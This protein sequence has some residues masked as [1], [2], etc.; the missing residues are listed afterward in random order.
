MT[1]Q[2]YSIPA[3]VRDSLLYIE[4]RD[5]LSERSRYLNPT[6]EWD[7]LAISLKDLFL[8][9][10]GSKRNIPG[11]STLA[12]Q[13]EK[14]RHSPRGVT[15]T[16]GDKYRQMYSA[17]LRAY[18]DGPDTSL[19][20]QEL[21]TR[22]MNS[23]PLAA[24][25]GYGEVLGLS[26]GLWAWYGTDFEK[27]NALLSADP[28]S[29][30]ENEKADRAKIYRQILSLFLAQR[31]PSYYLASDSG[32]E[33]LDQLTD[34]YLRRMIEDK[35]IPAALGESALKAGT[36]PN[37][38][39]PV[40]PAVQFVEKK[41]QYKIRSNLLGILNVDNLYDLDRLDLTVS[42]SINISEQ[43]KA[44]DFLRRMQDP[45]YLQKTGFRAESLLERGDPSQVMYSLIL[46]E[47]TP[48]GNHIRI[49]TDNFNGPFNI[50]E[51]SRLELGSTAKLRTLVFYLETIEKLHQELSSLPPEALRALP[52]SPKDAIGQWARQYLLDHP[53]ANLKEVLE[54]SLER[55][56]S[57][58]PGERF[59]TGGGV[60]TFAN[61]DP[62]WNGKIISVSEGF[63]N[64]VNLVWIRVMRDIVKHLI[65]R[66]PDSYGRVLEDDRHPARQEYLSRFAQYEGG[67]YV[68]RFYR[69]YAELSAESIL[70]KMVSERR[71]N[72][73]KVAWAFRAV[74]PAASPEEMRNFLENHTFGSRLT[75]G[76]P[77]DLYRKTDPEGQTLSDLGYLASVH[78]L[79]LWVVRYLLEHPG[80]KRSEVLDASQPSRQEAYR[81]LIKSS[82]RKA[83]DMRIRSILEMEA[84]SEV[85]QSWK[86]LGYP[87]D[88]I[89]PSLGT[90]IGSSG[91]RPAALANLVGI[92]LNDGVLLP[93]IQVERLQFAKGTP[94]E[95]TLQRKH[96][97]GSRVL[98]KEV[99][100]A[101]RETL[102]KVVEKGTAQ[103]IRGTLFDIHKNL[104]PIGGKTGTGNNRFRIFA[105][106]GREVSSYPLNRT[107]TFVFFLGNRYFGV[108]TAYI[109]GPEAGEYAFT[110]SLPV[111]ILRRLLPEL[112]L[113][114]NPYRDA[115]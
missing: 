111:E 69:K 77:E 19:K 95:V 109:S 96:Q 17:S 65:Y 67:V 6:I 89:V 51:G 108:I 13:I 39:P 5:L 45:D 38:K 32:K 9:M 73:V 30:D 43:R 81:W 76:S 21:V 92:L 68:E 104:I 53:S 84:F 86:R 46:A 44:T 74:N 114:Q 78:P 47:R 31:R 82:R 113:P 40:A 66:S 90:A 23:M 14:Y 29:L 20:R 50:N 97:E 63:Q 107:S 42:T 52:V 24:I 110:S 16:V 115:G 22:F 25:H 2:S 33:K 105:P 11:A 54:A 34:Q 79:E 8:R 85:L 55:K 101:V 4:N 112:E 61:F 102:L 88:N 103:R 27:A 49:Q 62:S 72:P 71:L 83:Q 93:T 57:A 59:I 60:Q 37:L 56:Y 48:D 35:V 75:D 3:A 80:A 99:A 98:S 100:T 10:P 7:R 91:D 18:L 87:F 15:A 12:T 36:R 64:S 41:A 26:D 58:D 94:F 106:G 70:N 28:D 1:T